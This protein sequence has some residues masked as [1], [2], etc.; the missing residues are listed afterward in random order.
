MHSVS[1]NFGHAETI[2]FTGSG[3]IG[4][5]QH[6]PRIFSRATHTRSDRKESTMK[7]NRIADLNYSWYW[8]RVLPLIGELLH[9]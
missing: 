6:D 7:Q 9:H 3:R 2:G 4:Q 8:R 1:D 5:G